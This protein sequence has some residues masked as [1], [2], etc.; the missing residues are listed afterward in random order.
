MGTLKRNPWAVAWGA[1]AAVLLGS[2]LWMAPARADRRAQEKVSR[3]NVAAPG[4]NT[5]ILATDIQPSPA[6]RGSAFRVT[7][8]LETASVLNV[9]ATDGVT[10]KTWGL[11]TSNQLQANDKYAFVFSTHPD[12]TYNFQVET[13]GV[14]SLL[15]VQEIQDGTT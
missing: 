6:F 2:I 14:I 12:L 11:N 4:A 10:T 1:A 3:F 13:D 9:T 5:D 15:V 7:V 8:V